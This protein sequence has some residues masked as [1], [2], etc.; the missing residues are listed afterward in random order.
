MPYG[1]YKGVTSGKIGTPEANRIAEA[2]AK[3]VMQQYTYQPRGQVAPEMLQSLG[4]LLEATKLPPVIPE[5]AMLA[6]IPRQAV[7]AQAERTGMAAERAVAPIVNRTMAKGGVGAG[8]LD[9]FATQ[10][11]AMAKNKGLP[12]PQ[13]LTMPSVPTVD[14]M[15]QYG[16]TEV[17]PL[18]KA[19]SFQSAR[20]W[21]KFNAGKGPG[22]LVAG[23]GDKPLALRL[24][25]GEYVIY[26][27]N[28]RTDLALQKGQTELPMNVID[29]KSYDPAH[30]GRKPV[31][32][33]MTDDELLNSLLGEQVVA[34]QTSGL[35]DQTDLSY[36][37][38]HS[39]PG[40]DF[41]APLHDLTGGGQ[42]YPADVYSEKA[43]QYYGSGNRRADIE[44][45]NLANRVRGNPDAEV[46]MYRAVPKN[47]DIS[48]IN[49]GDWVTLTKD[50]AKT[51]GESVFG[52]DY[53]ILSQKVKAKD[54]WTNADS[55]QEFGYQPQ[56]LLD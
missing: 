8:L 23:Y 41:G 13:S 10:P 28:H 38:F 35:L 22:D 49:A 55:I 34:P 9:S 25:T 19:V 30:A 40:P 48:A 18:S 26:D 45:F 3:R 24:E 6:S 15:K 1:V 11:A 14:Q 52:K 4:G 5:A 43:V 27:G 32:S 44:A 21:E 50:Y 31:P 51:H 16:R 33:S 47:A 20:N 54:L 36:R 37:G 29:V 7:A 12:S 56:G 42:M 2:E 39:A 46:T 17:V 53:K